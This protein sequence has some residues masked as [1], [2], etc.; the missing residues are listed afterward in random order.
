VCLGYGPG[1]E[2]ITP[3]HGADWLVLA[4]PEMPR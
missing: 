1:R 3:N 2:E 4:E